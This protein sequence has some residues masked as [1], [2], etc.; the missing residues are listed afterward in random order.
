MQSDLGLSDTD[1]IVEVYHQGQRARLYVCG[2][3]GGVEISIVLDIV[4]AAIHGGKR[5]RIVA[6]D[7]G[8]IARSR[9]FMRPN[10]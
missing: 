4:D 7:L 10:A 6:V 1:V 3:V 5:S 8:D 2:I 9:D